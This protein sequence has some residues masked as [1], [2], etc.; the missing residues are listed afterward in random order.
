MRWPFSPLRPQALRAEIFQLGGRHLG[1]PLA[2]AV[3]ELADTSIT[4]QRRRLL[5]AVVKQLRPDP[6][7]TAPWPTRS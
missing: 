2:G 3:L 5:E 6:K 4:A 7:R 1:E